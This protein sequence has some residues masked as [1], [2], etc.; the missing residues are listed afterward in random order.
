[1]KR[2]FLCI[3]CSFVALVSYAGPRSLPDKLIDV[4][5]E[6]IKTAGP[7]E[8]AGQFVATMWDPVWE[9]RV[10]LAQVTIPYLTNTDPVKVAGALAVLYR[11]RGYTPLNDIGSAGRPSAWEQKYQPASFWAGLDEKV[12]AN[13]DHFHSV[14]TQRVFMNLALYLGVVHSTQAKQELLRIAGQTDEGAKDQALIC[15]TWHRAPKDM[16]DLLPFMLA[17]SSASRSLPY[18]F[19]NSYGRAA[20]PFLKKAVSEA[21]SDATR[22]E[23]E[24]ELKIL[25]KE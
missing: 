14:G 10:E 4:T 11:L 9:R 13:L 6:H 21:K 15:L 23:A 22:R 5:I 16:P 18:H 19:R 8:D 17:D 3:F 24:K 12:L 1:M 25:E 7:D 20:I 2:L